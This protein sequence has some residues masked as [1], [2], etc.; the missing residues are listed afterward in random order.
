MSIFFHRSVKLIIYK[1]YIRPISEYATPVYSGNLNK[2]YSDQLENLQRQA[3]MAC[4]GA[5]RHT[6]HSKLLQETGIEPLS[7]RR[8]YYGLCHLYKIING[9]TPSYLRDLLPPF[10]GE[11]VGYSLRNSDCSLIPHTTKSYVLNS[12]SWNTPVH[13]NK[14]SLETRQSSSLKQF[15]K[16]LR[17][18][19][20]T[21]F[22]SF[23]PVLI[24]L[25][26]SMS[27]RSSVQHSRMRM[28][29][30]PLNA[31]G[32]SYNFINN[33]VCPLCSTIIENTFHYFLK[34]PTLA[35]QRVT[36]MNRVT[37]ILNT[38]NSLNINIFIRNSS[39]LHSLLLHG[40]SLLSLEINTCIF[41]AV[42]RYINETNRFES[43]RIPYV[44]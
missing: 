42:H 32:H 39:D 34:C 33:N 31:H 24:Q 16:G 23:Q 26:N 20:R 22:P 18:N 43:L 7:I 21:E 6:S 14:L 38:V 37:N 4:V 10:V 29:L 15:K 1:N 17:L 9:L 35:N 12:F 44:V 5:Y 13:W 19:L 2:F 36:L 11:R 25:Y 28:G 41:S 30:S 40:S 8:K 3:L 27:G